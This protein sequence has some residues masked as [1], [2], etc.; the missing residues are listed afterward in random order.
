MFISIFRTLIVYVLVIFI[1]RFMGKRQI[2]TLQ[3]SELAVTILVSNLAS[4]PVENLDIPL[5]LGIT[6]LLI[7]LCFEYIFSMVGLKS[8]KFRKIL[9][10]KPIFVIENGVINQKALTK[11]RFTVD[12]LTE[13]LRGCG[14]FN[15]SDVAY[16]IVE[17]NGKMNII[18]KFQ[19]SSVTPKLL[20]FK[21]EKTTIPLVI[22]SDGKLIKSNLKYINIT[23]NWVENQVKEQNLK[24]KDVFIMTADENREI[25]LAKKEN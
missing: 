21:N 10:G 5:I 8:R 18:K 6:P 11:L 25:F 24:I 7:L 19:S 15:I 1:M 20:N 17:T 9:S 23:K 12:D 2:A 4:M 13:N 3:P 22:V 16:A 14:V